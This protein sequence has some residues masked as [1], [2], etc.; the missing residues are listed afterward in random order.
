[1]GQS[2]TLTAEQLREVLHYD[3]DTGAFV[4]LVS[5]AQK[6]KVGDRAGTI[7]SNGYRKITI[8]GRRYLAARLAHL[9]MTGEWPEHL[10]D[11]RDG[12]R[13]NDRWENLRPATRNQNNANRR[14][15]KSG[16]KGAYCWNGRWFSS[17]EVDGKAIYLGSFP[18]EFDA[19]AAYVKA[20][21]RCFGEFARAA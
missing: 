5:L 4:W 15:L 9:Y 16:L 1:M 21:E 17:I 10:M 8:K 20:A 7:H 18:S 3:G 19:H 11:H 12:D 14:R 13:S 6:I 2:I